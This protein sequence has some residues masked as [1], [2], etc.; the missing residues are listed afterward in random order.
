[1]TTV[2]DSEAADA[3]SKRGDLMPL[4]FILDIMRDDS[5]PLSIRFEA[6]KA[7]LP[8]C[9]AKQASIKDSGTGEFLSQEEALD[10]LR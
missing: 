3:A 9:H 7:A 1:M 8:Y 10:Q 6:A 2:K 5:A 4:D